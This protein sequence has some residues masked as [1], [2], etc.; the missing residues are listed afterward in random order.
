MHKSL[1][2]LILTD[3]TSWMNKYNADLK[4]KLEKLGHLVKLIHSKNELENSDVAF[5]LSCFE[6]I[7]NN[8]LSLSKN[9]IV[10]HASNL[11]KGKGWSPAS[12]QILEGKNIIP[13]TLFEASEKVDAGDIYL[14]DKL[15]L[16]GC[17]LIDE[18]QD[19]L[20]KKIVQ[21]CI[22]YVSK[23]KKMKGESQ[24]GEE[25]FYKKRTPKDSELDINK[26]IKEQFN[27]FRIVD[28]EKYPAFFKFKDKTYILKIE[29]I[30]PQEREREKNLTRKIKPLFFRIEAA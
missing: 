3:S 24:R 30:K 16:D 7:S 11:P 23:Y 29:S 26:T 5:F 21:M 1:K 17:E 12:W 15:V 28:N 10:V 25:T 2:I 13:L 27:L 20:G 4:Q 6:I 14:Q 19:K 22:T 18:W 8:L 9:N